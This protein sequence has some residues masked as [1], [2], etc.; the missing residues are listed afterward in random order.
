MVYKVVKS[1]DCEGEYYLMFYSRPLVKLTDFDK[2]FFCKKCVVIKQH[3]AYYNGT[4]YNNLIIC[5]NHGEVR[6]HACSPKNFTY[7]IF[8][9]EG[10]V[11][12][13]KEYANG[14]TEHIWCGDLS[15]SYEDMME[16]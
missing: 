13:Y 15:I 4:S 14:K 12:V 8:E 9:Q 3:E 7:R 10:V 1:E 16:K 5:S 6:S 2:V 11:Q